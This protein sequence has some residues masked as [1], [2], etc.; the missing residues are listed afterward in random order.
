[1]PKK[2]FGDVAL[3]LVAFMA[4][5][6][7]IYVLQGVLQMHLK[8]VAADPITLT[9]FAAVLGFL[10]FRTHRLVP[11]ILLHMALNGTSLLLA[12]LLSGP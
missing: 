11:S 9:V 8:E 7:P 5:A 10:Y 3:G 4:V 12:G 1:M 6:A 2:F